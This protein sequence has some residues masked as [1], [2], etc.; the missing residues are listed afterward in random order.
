MTAEEFLK[1]YD[2]FKSGKLYGRYIT[3][4]HLEEALEDFKERYP[5]TE[6]GRSFL[7]IPIPGITVGTGKKKIL[8]WSQMH[9]NES[10]S[11]KG[12][13]DLLH[14]LK[15]YADLDVVKNILAECTILILPM[16]NPDGAARYTRVNVNKVDLLSL[17]HI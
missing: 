15:V 9:G 11:T 13:V 5:I 7:N 6:V 1:N 10:T 8:A 14:F 3:Y 16:V 17:I 4:S 12:V 2:E